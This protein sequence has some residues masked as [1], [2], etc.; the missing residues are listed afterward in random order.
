MTSVSYKDVN[1]FTFHPQPGDQV[2]LVH[3]KSPSEE[4]WEKEKM[5]FP[6]QPSFANQLYWHRYSH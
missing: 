4:S 5:D 1:D 6:I 2:L 3:N